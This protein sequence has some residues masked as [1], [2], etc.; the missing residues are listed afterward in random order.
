M[1]EE[2]VLD[3]EN[4]DAVRLWMKGVCEQNIPDLVIA[5]A[6]RN[7]DIGPNLEGEDFREARALVQV[8]LL[9]GMALFD[10]TL[11]FFR[12]Q[13][14]GQFAFIS[15]L[16][17]YYGLAMTPTYCATKAALKSYGTSLRAWLLKENIH[18]NVIFPGYVRSPMCEAM[19]GP[20]P[21]L[22]E[23]AKAARRIRKGLERDF[24]R[25]SFPF[26]L[27]LGVWGLGLLPL[28]LA[29]PIAKILGYGPIQFTQPGQ[30]VPSRQETKSE[31]A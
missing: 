22:M 4:T 21:F 5:N 12:K 10:A 25:I 11:P 14:G 16:A 26:P 6:G 19:P 31:Q 18:V 23:P 1:V 20:K 13:G 9:S 30:S 17:G 29:M 3:L 27:D 28:C 8:N 15:S 7:T 24:A 2:H